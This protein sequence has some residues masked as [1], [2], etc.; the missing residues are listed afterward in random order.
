[1][2]STSPAH[3]TYR[4][5]VRLLWSLCQSIASCSGRATTRATETTSTDF[6]MMTAATTVPL[7]GSFAVGSFAT[8]PAGVACGPSVN[9][10]GG[11]TRQLCAD[12]QQSAGLSTPMHRSTSTSELSAKPSEHRI[13][14]NAS[15]SSSRRRI[16]DSIEQPNRIES[17]SGTE[18][19]PMPLRAEPCSDAVPVRDGRSTRL[20]GV[21]VRSIVTV[22]SKRAIHSHRAR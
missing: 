14:A 9:G 2:Y 1:M 10:S 20:I 22:D 21:S 6:S 7:S 13:V 17:A 3:I 11:A 5:R 19:N 12:F 8:R 16:R 4:N 18:S 15:G